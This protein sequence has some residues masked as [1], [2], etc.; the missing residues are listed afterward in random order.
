V[1][2]SVKH[3]APVG[4]TLR[5]ICIGELVIKREITYSQVVR[6]NVNECE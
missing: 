1:G 4:G 6:V 2:A 3:R 5:V